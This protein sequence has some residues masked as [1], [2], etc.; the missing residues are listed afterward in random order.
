MSAT[1]I[2]AAFAVS[3]GSAQAADTLRSQQW[4]LDAMHAEEMWQTST[5]AGVT[6]AVIDSGVDAELPDLRGQVLPGEDFSG[7]A[8]GAH[9]DYEGHGTSMAVLIAGTGKSNAGSGSF[10]L[11]PGVK[12]LPLRVISDKAPATQKLPGVAMSDAIRFAADSEAKIINISMG[13][14]GEV[15]EQKKAVEYALSKGKLVFA[16]VGN[17]GRKDNAVVFPAAF[18][19][20]VGVAAVDEDIKATAESEHGPQ[21]DL[22]APGDNMVTTC[23]GGTGICRGHG[24]SDATALASASAALLW[25]V[26]PDWTANQITRV[27]INTAGGPQNGDKRS[28]SIGYGVVR[29]RIAL[30]NPGDPGPADV[31][32]LPGPNY[33]SPAPQAT[34]SRATGG[35]PGR[36]TANPADKADGLL[37]TRNVLA[38]GG[39]AVVAVAVAVSVGLK[40]RRRSRQM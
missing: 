2:L 20:V 31:N 16:S 34:A 38:A 37:S 8:G 40:R 27:L 24:T 21:V 5:G 22:A 23:K 15:P 18:P 14:P 35:M 9:S 32:P 7:I 1:T 36:S 29:P 11:A 12:I 4:Y 26:H 17:R 39:A 30:K 28:D 13:G 19:G 33:A 6:V 25:S 3:V 10:G